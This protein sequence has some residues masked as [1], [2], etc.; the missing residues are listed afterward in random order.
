MEKELLV[1]E[2]LPKGKEFRPITEILTE[3]K[4][5]NFVQAIGT[6]NPLHVDKAY[7][8]NSKFGDIV[9]PPVI[10]YL[11]FR[12]SYLADANMPGGGVALKLEFE[13]LKGAKVNETLITQT[14]VLDSYER[15]GKKYVTLEG[16]TKNAEGEKVFVS[17]L[18]TIWPK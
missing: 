4:I 18:H 7:A 2:N 12:R 1:F 15:E 13:F 3:E 14:K 10:S 6:Q 5:R 11:L 16:V 9:A 8:K 17:R